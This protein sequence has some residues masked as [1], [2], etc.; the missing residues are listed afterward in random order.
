[1]CLLSPRAQAN[2]APPT[3][4]LEKFR[5]NFPT[6]HCTDLLAFPLGGVPPLQGGK[7]QANSQDTGLRETRIWINV[8]GGNSYPSLSFFLFLCP[9]D[10]CLIL[11]WGAPDTPECVKGGVGSF[12]CSPLL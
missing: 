11:C 7:G 2:A 8:T 1:M 3:L 4:S 9:A 12:L 5:L 10:V 6:D